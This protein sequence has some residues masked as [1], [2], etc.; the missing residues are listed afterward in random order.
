MLLEASKED[1]NRNDTDSSTWN[2]LT[3]YQNA[4]EDTFI[5]GINI[6]QLNKLNNYY[7]ADIVPSHKSYQ[8]S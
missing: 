1:G 6:I 3:L 2:Q 7:V 4:Y 8:D 5:R